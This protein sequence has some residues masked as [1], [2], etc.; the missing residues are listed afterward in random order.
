MRV[1]LAV[2]LLSV[3]FSLQAQ[4][5]K[6]VKPVELSELTDEIQR[7]GGNPDSIS[8][9]L[10]LPIEFWESVIGQNPDI[11]QAAANELLG[12]LEQYDMFA[13]LKGSVGANGTPTYLNEE[14]IFKKT[15]LILPGGNKHKPIEESKLSA[16]VVEIISVMKPILSNMLGNLGESMTFLIFESH[17]NNKRLADPYQDGSLKM[18]VSGEKFEWRLPLNSLLEEKH[19]PIDKETL[20]GSW[21][22]CPHHGAKL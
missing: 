2:L 12:K 6:K 9:S 20:K 3:S 21:K 13:V 15:Y 7:S 5:Q 16:E 10:W 11:D 8:L 22:F 1:T 18:I 4:Y 17:Q 19:C 14:T